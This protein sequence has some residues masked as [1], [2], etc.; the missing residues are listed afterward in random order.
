MIGLVNPFVGCAIESR[1]TRFHYRQT[2][3]AL[4]HFRM[5]V[6]CFFDISIGG[7]K[8]GRIVFELFS[9]IVPKTSENFRALCTGEKETVRQ[10]DIPK[11]FGSKL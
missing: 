6:K 1:K 2:Y 3:R 4:F 7:K 9:D 10:L 8:E 11:Y 5:A